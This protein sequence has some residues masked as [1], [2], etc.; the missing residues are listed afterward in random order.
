MV[1]SQWKDPAHTYLKLAL[2]IMGQTSHVSLCDAPLMESSCQK[3]RNLKQIERTSDKSK[4]RDN[5]NIS[6]SLKTK[7]EVMVQIKGA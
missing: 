6:R 2:P 5:E 4:L 7:N 3:M 1:T